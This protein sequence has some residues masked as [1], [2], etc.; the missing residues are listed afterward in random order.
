MGQRRTRPPTRGRRGGGT[1]IATDCPPDPV[2]EPVEAMASTLL[3][4]PQGPPRCRPFAAAIKDIASL[5]TRPLEASEVVFCLDEKTSIQ[6]RGRT[7]ATAPAA[8]RRPVRVEQEYR[9]DGALNLFAAFNTRTGEVIHPGALSASAPRSS[10]PS[11]T[12]STPS[13]RQR[14]RPSTSC[15]TTSACTKAGQPKTGSPDTLASTSTSRQSTV[16]G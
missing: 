7:A 4:L 2:H 10:S 1:D 3:A 14:R 6:P 5:Y 13:S 16:L 12:C 11:S 15:S 9:R 8:P